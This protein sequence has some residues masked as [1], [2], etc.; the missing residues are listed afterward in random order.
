MITR[1]SGACAEDPAGGLQAVHVGHP[2]VHQHD[3][4]PQLRRRRH[5]LGPVG[6]LADHLDAARGEDHPEAGADQV[7]VV[8][9][10]HPGRP[11]P[12]S[13]AVQRDAGADAVAAAEA[14]PG[15]QV[16]AVDGDPLAQ[17][18]QPAPRAVPA[19]PAASAAARLPPPDSTLG[20]AVEHLHPQGS[21]PRTGR[22]PRPCA[23]SP[24]LSALVS[25][26]WTIRYAVTSIPAGSGRGSPEI[27][28]STGSPAKAIR[29]I[30]GPRRLRLGCGARSA[31]VVRRPRR[32]RGREQAQQVPQLG[33]R[34][35]A[36]VLDGRAAPRRPRPASWPAP[37]GRPRPGPPSGSR[38]G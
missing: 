36:G 24:C 17:A 22:S 38:C 33:H 12:P 2:D 18:E 11:R 14:A 20:P 13:R 3:V 9:D 34:V 28:T 29:S 7:L 21:G 5:R 35:A 37:R 4:G 32:R 26:S 23:P 15:V 25:A 27:R 16:A 31:A 10:E 6:G 8:G 1:Q 19:P 30:S